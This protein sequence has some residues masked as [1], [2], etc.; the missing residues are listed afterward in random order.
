MAYDSWRVFQGGYPQRPGAT[1]QHRMKPRG[2][3]EVPSNRP[4]RAPAPAP[5]PPP[6]VPAA[7]ADETPPD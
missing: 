4:K 6:P 1:P 5:P 2:V 3:R 7:E